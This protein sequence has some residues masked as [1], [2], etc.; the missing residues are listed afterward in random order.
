MSATS[1][2]ESRCTN[3]LAG[4]KPCVLIRGHRGAC[5]FHGYSESC[6]LCSGTGLVSFSYGG[7]GYGDRCAALAD[8]DDQP[9]PECDATG[10][11]DALPD[12]EV[13]P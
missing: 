11:V 3:S 8:A 13:T 4:E 2:T 9:C 6:E 7:D 5:D 10:R 1:H 12:D